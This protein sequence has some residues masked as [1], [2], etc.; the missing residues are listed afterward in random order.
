MRGRRLARGG[1]R[2]T[3]CFSLSRSVPTPPPVLVDFLMDLGRHRGLHPY[4]VSAE[5]VDSGRSASGRW[6][7][8]LVRER[9]RLGPVRYPVRFRARTTRTSS[10]SMEYDVQLS[11]AVRLRGTTRAE[12]D[13]DGSTA[14]TETLEV[15]APRLLVGYVTR[16]ARLAHARTLDRLPT[17]LA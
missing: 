10:T 14:V 17:T 8:W 9:P 4:L 12:V 13:A 11:R 1:W 15:T 16:Q 2:A 7:E 5:V 6:Q 3:R